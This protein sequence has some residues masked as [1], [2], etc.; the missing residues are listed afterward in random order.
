MRLHRSGVI[1]DRRS[2]VEIMEMELTVGPVVIA[3]GG[4]AL[5]NVNHSFECTL[6]RRPAISLE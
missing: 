1:S 4:F 3:F 6:S 2:E 5:R